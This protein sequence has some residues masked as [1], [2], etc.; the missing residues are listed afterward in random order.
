M[1]NWFKQILGCKEQQLEEE[2]A[3]LWNENLEL[4]NKLKQFAVNPKEEE[5]NNK[6][7]KKVITYAGRTLANGKQMV[8][9]D[10]R[11]FFTLY[12]ENIKLIVDKFSGDD[13][14]KAVECLSWVI[15]NIKYI[16]DKQQLGIE[17]EWMFPYETLITLKGDCDDGA[18]L[19]AN[20]IIISG[21]P[22]W[23][24]RLTT[25]LV[26]NGD[27]HCYVT[28]Y[29]E[30]QDS[31]KALDWCYFPNKL[32]IAQRV[33]YKEDKLYNA[34]WFSWNVKFGFYKGVN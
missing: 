7:P 4:K 14:E 24:V 25:G 10:V 29:C 17:E 3:K 33:E 5:L 13:D 16:T 31:W 22:Y 6:Y 23:K 11:N 8:D 20:M 27:G 12:D 19:M 34:V 32:P 21:V 15:D 30:E 9:I 26:S 2:K 28:Y 1:I 18:I